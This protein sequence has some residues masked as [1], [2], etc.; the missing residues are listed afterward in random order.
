MGHTNKK[1]LPQQ[2][3]PVVETTDYTDTGFFFPYLALMIE[4]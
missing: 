3:P 1:F 4:C 2:N